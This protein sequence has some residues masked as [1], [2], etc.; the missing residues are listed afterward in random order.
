ME[1]SMHLASLFNQG[2][3]MRLAKH[4][5]SFDNVTVKRGSVIVAKGDNLEVSDF[6]SKV[7][8]IIKD[9][10]GCTCLKSGMSVN[11]GDIGGNT[12]TLLK[13]PQILTVSG[14]K[15]YNNEVGMIWHYFDEVV[16]YPITISDIADLSQIKL[17][18]YNTII[19]PDGSYTLNDDIMKELNRWV[20]EG[21]KLIVMAGAL[22]NFL[23]KE[24]WALSEYATQEEKDNAKKDIEQVTLM[25]RKDAYHD[26]ERALLSDYIPGTIIENNLDV[27]HPLSFGLGEKYYSLKTNTQ[28]YKLLKNCWN[29]VY[30]PKDYK[31]Y[32]FIGKNLKSKISETMTYAVEQ[33]SRGN[34]IYMVD[35]PL[36]RG[37]WENGNLLFSNAVFLV[38]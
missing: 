12:F 7:W 25:K 29:P 38:W 36:F 27:T 5:V 16:N 17:S 10:E 11:G 3:Q 8:N 1:S 28:L 20:K 4:D 6:D 13:K 23:D 21:G 30:V 35:N 33:K 26:R 9:K 22:T 31:S 14:E 37:F 2:F 18:K 24:G 32:G 19:L 15:T 34:V